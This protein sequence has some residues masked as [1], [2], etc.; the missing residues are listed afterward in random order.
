M[1]LAS[2]GFMGYLWDYLG[3]KMSGKEA[4]DA[5]KLF[6]LSYEEPVEE[7]ME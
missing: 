6:F 3:T 1:R 4:S 2:I 7:K 5:K